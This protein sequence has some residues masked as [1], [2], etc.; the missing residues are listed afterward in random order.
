MRYA[1]RYL[2]GYMG[3]CFSGFLLD[4]LHVQIPSRIYGNAFSVD[5]ERAV[6]SLDTFKDIWELEVHSPFDDPVS[7]FR[8]LQGY[9]GTDR[10]RAY[11]LC[12][13]FVQIPSRIY[14]NYEIFER[15]DT[16][17]VVQ[18]PSRIY[19]NSPFCHRQRKDSWFRYL[20]GYMGTS[21]KKETRSRRKRFRYLQGYMGTLSSSQIFT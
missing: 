14:G 3:T 21:L 2:Q 15:N 18:I 5:S 8:Y 11:K 7:L 20:Q 12:P 19:G 10:G 9:M 1:F 4:D 17:K 6:L 13:S 16:G